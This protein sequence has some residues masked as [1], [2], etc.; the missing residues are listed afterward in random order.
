MRSN[1]QIH[2]LPLILLVLLS[3]PESAAQNPVRSAAP[4]NE[5]KAV[6]TQV[7]IGSIKGRVV[8][9]E[10]QPAANISVTAFPIGRRPEG[11]PGGGGQ[12]A[13]AMTDEEGNFQIDGLSPA[14]YSIASSA[15]GYITLPPE[16][17]ESAGVYRLGD[18]ASITLVKGGVITGKVMSAD[19]EPLT[20]VSVNAVRTGNLEGEEDFSPV[21]AGFGRNW[22]TD[23][24]GVYRIY[25]LAPSSYVVRAGGGTGNFTSAFSEDAPTYYPSSPRETAVVVRAPA[26]AEVSG[27]DIRYR[28]EK[29]RTVSGKVIDK[30]GSESNRP[31]GVEIS[32]RVAGSDT[33]IASAFQMGGGGRRGNRGGG[34]DGFALRGVPDGEYEVVARRGGFGG[35][36]S[37][38]ASAPRRI[39]VRGADVGGIELILA[40]LATLNG[41]VVIERRTG[42]ASTA[43]STV[44]SP[45]ACQGPRRSFAGEILLG[46]QRD[47]NP[48]RESSTAARSTSTPLAAPDANSEFTLRNLDAGI[49]RLSVQLPD[50]NW[51][52]RSMSLDRAPAPATRRPSASAAASPAVKVARDGIAIK[53]GEKVSGLIVAIAEGAAGVKGQVVK[54]GGENVAGNLLVLLVPAEKE[55]ADNLLRYAQTVTNKEGAFNLKHLA[56]GRYLLLA[57]PL[58]KDAAENGSDRLIARDHAKRLALRSEAEAYAKVVELKPCQRISDSKLD[59]REK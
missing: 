54:A 37:G 46:A 3:A 38:A 14:S 48:P 16:N 25:G 51:Y 2:F 53:A 8:D 11:R 22:R 36:E 39:S 40:P 43:N 5:A 31:G 7:V 18:F 28:G 57:K 34:D 23:D 50:E 47:D 52:V 24:L 17:E 12:P 55:A 56:P 4:A 59:I 19:G 32:L 45:D 6:A 35:A 58:P 49:Y 21:T 15:P 29:G 20:G 41:R 9:S 26:G 30:G 1:R 33:V 13:Q 44:V 27:I 42:A 10:G